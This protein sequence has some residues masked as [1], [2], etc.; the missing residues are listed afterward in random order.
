MA[1]RRPVIKDVAALAGVSWKTVSNVMN[2]RPV[3][4][5]ETRQRVLDAVATLGYTP[6][7]A[8]RDLREG[9]SRSVAL[10]LPELE[11]PYF[12]RLAEY[13][14]RALAD[15]GRTLS[16]E[17]TGGDADREAAY[18]QGATARE[19]SAVLLSATRVSE[20]S[21]V[22]RPDWTPLVLLGERVSNVAVPHIA[23]DNAGATVD[24]VRHL[25][26]GGRRHIGFIGAPE[27]ALPSTGSVRLA[28]FQAAM[29][30]A[31]LPVANI[32][33]CIDWNRED[34]YRLMQQMLAVGDPLDAVVCAN[35]LMAIGAV[36]ALVESGRR[37]PDDVAL[38]GFDDIAEAAW[39]SPPLTT[40]R[41]DLELL[42]RHALDA[43]LTPDGVRERG[44]EIVVPHELV[45][46][47]SSAP[48]G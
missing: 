30:F 19:F 31:D 41:P 7:H 22:N 18:L 12:A 8:G 5:P 35:D 27:S 2:D 23:I 42:V 13:A 24:L 45:V 17:L 33:R 14:E 4:K 40:I 46:R 26:A 38:V 34:G 1:T 29:R 6:N 28:G 15:R 43:A 36:R 11:N 44:S 3:V 10:V 20:Q 16:I 32:Q 37:V 47:A 25:V 21:V 9:R 48:K 39:C